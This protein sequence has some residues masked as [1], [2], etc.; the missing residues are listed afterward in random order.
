MGVEAGS[1]TFESRPSIATADCPRPCRPGP[2]L[3]V[4]RRSLGATEL[5]KALGRQRAALDAGMRS[6][7]TDTAGAIE[8]FPQEVDKSSS[9]FAN[10]G[11]LDAVDKTNALHQDAALN[12]IQD[13]KHCSSTSPAA[14]QHLI[15]LPSPS[16]SSRSPQIYVP[17]IGAG[18]KMRD[19]LDANSS[20]GHLTSMT[21][22][23]LWGT[24]SA[25]LGLDAS[26]AGVASNMA[27][28]PEIFKRAAADLSVAIR[29]NR[30]TWTVKLSMPLQASFESVPFAIGSFK[31]VCF[32]L[33]TGDSDAD[34]SWTLSLHG[35]SLHDPSLHPHNMSIKLFCD[36]KVTE[37][38]EWTGDSPLEAQFQPRLNGRASVVCGLLYYTR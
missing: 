35:L 23:C 19:A 16:R 33:R 1:A 34:G 32:R 18:L 4:P 36:M 21:S 25:H 8:H 13:D 22:P 12:P 27:E 10:D 17:E 24:T 14:T 5:E 9:H 28:Q 30:V 31:S 37:S 26:I 11:Q 38:K 29:G 3:R 2:A 6:A 20:C 15:H 7:G